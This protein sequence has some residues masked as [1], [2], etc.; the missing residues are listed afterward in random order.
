MRTIDRPAIETIV[1][2]DLFEMPL[3]MLLP[4]AK[5]EALQPW[6]HLFEGDHVDYAR[7]MLRIAIKSHIARV[8]G[9]TILVDACI[10]E[11]KE[12]PQR[13]EWHQRQGTDFLGKLAQA[14]CRAEDIDI[15]M[16]T[17]L[18]ADHVGWNT[19]LENGRWTPTFPNARYI[20]GGEELD[21]WQTQAAKSSGVNHGSYQDS[22]LPIL[23]AGM[24]ETVA[25]HDEIAD[26]AVIVPLPG[27][28]AGHMG[29]QVPQLNGPDVLFCGDAIH[30]PVQVPYPGWASFLCFDPSAAIATRQSI[31]ER[32]LSSDLVLAPAHVRTAFGMRVKRDGA[33]HSPVFCD[34]SGRPI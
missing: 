19:R 10:G 7:G 5:V 13:A 31:I 8:G 11:H 6:R 15:V 33:H 16:C 22:V 28:T 25:A 2:L 20:V 12:R 26:G 24:I 30:S 14:G 18:H 34:C 17:H 4:A 29:L 23:E 3:S 27:H 32:A 1:D 21:Y 9:K